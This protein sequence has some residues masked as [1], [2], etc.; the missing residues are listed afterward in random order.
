MFLIRALA[1][2][3]LDF[4]IEEELG[5]NKDINALAFILN[6]TSFS[7]N[8]FYQPRSWYNALD[9]ATNTEIGLD[10][11]KDEE[12]DEYEGQG[13]ELLVQ[14]SQ[15]MGGAKWKHMAD[16]LGKLRRYPNSFVVPYQKTFY[17]GA[18]EAYWDRI[19]L[20]RYELYMGEV[21]AQNALPEDTEEELIPAMNQLRDVITWLPYDDEVMDR[22]TEEMRVASEK[23]PIWTGD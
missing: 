2:P 16:W 1:L 8:A 6:E 13:G 22:A 4:S 5:Y 3:M 18:I 12:E 17:P 11:R 9:H 23:T 19:R 10:S 7:S 20:A 15:P 14:F 21:T